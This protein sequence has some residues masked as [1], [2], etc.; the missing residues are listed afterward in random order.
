MS[1]ICL[2]LVPTSHGGCFK[3]PKACLFD[4]APWIQVSRSSSLL[5]LVKPEVFLV[6]VGMG[7]FLHIILFAF[8][9]VAIQ[10]LSTVS[11]G[12]QS[13]FAKKENANAFVLVSSQ[14][15]LPVMVAV[16][17]QLGGAF[18]ETGLLV[19][20]CVAAHLNQIIVDSFLVN[21]WLRGD[22][23]SKHAKVA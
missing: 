14:K 9:A 13:V 8:N 23:A 3:L 16:A 19:L 5:L 7:V 18:G 4:Q 1:A 6:A 22:L 10:G 15:T 20:P 11:G 21:F 17:E 2:S 12:N